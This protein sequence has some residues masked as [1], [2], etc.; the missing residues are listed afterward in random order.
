[1]ATT[2]ARGRWAFVLPDSLIAFGNRRHARGGSTLGL[3]KQTLKLIFM[4]TPVTS[5][6]IDVPP[7]HIEPTRRVL[8]IELKGLQQFGN[9]V[10]VPELTRCRDGVVEVVASSRRD[11]TREPM[12]PVLPVHL[13]CDAQPSVPQHEPLECGGVQRRVALALHVL[14]DPGHAAREE[15]VRPAHRRRCSAVL[16]QHDDR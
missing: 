14:R 1:M 13:V 12:F 16:R 8:V 2:T 11:A 4:R 10:A 6:E 7:Q 9:C 15:P 5:E 3:T